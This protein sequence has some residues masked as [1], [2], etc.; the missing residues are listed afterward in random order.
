MIDLA[1]PAIGRKLQHLSHADRP[2]LIAI[3]R[4]TRRDL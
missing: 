4:G 1:T 3:L 2:A